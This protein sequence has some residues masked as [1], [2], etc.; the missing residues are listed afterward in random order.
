MFIL[1]LPGELLDGRIVTQP[2]G[3]TTH[4]AFA[5]QKYNPGPG[6]LVHPAFIVPVNRDQISEQETNTTIIIRSKRRSAKYYSEITERHTAT[7]FPDDFSIDNR[8]RSL[9]PANEIRFAVRPL[10]PRS[11]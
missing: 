7:D 8:R 4:G 11:R 3:A 9:V 1:G 5:R 2:K 10:S 6:D